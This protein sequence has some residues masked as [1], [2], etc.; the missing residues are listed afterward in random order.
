MCIK[1]FTTISKVLFLL[2]IAWLTVSHVQAQSPCEISCNATLPVCSESAVTLSV[3]NDYQRTYLWN[4]GETTN[5]ITVRPYQT[6]QYSV[7]VM[8][9]SGNTIC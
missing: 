9:L 8:D 3:P 5:S 6:T 2:M 1:P 4:T 7:K